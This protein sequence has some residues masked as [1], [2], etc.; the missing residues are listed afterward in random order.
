MGGAKRI[1]VVY[2]KAKPMIDIVT[3]LRQKAQ[4]C[5]H[6]YR[7]G[8]GPMGPKP[9]EC[10]ACRQAVFVADEIERLNTVISDMEESIPKLIDGARRPLLREIKRLQAIVTETVPYMIADVDFALAMG[11]PPEGHDD[12]DC[13]DCRW[14]KDADKLRA[15]IDAGEFNVRHGERHH[16]DNGKAGGS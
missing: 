12:D 11:P 5:D 16:L 3:R 13:D 4:W 14:Y 6:G 8:G 10:S 15:R 2:V 9:T 7:N 1:T